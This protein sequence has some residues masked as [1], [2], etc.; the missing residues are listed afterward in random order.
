MKSSCIESD[1]G[2]TGGG[3][4]RKNC[5]LK[6]CSRSFRK[7]S[8]KMCSSEGYYS[9]AMLNYLIAGKRYGASSGVI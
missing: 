1:T 6:L 4:E 5:L 9:L 2:G 8:I 7:R 3:R